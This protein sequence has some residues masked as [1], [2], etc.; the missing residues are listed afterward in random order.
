MNHFT[1]GLTTVAPRVW[2]RP[3]RTVRIRRRIGALLAT[4]FVLPTLGLAATAAPAGADDLALKQ[5]QAARIVAQLNA[6]GQ[7][8]S[9]LAE[10]LDQARVKAAALNQ[11]VAQAQASLAQTTAQMSAVRGRLTAQA[12]TA[13]ISGGGASVVQLLTAG[14]GDDLALRRHYA[15]T[16]AGTERG[17][18]EAMRSAQQ[19]L[20]ARQAQL[21]ADQK[22]AKAA[23]DQVDA[24]Q[25][26]AGSVDAQN[27]ALLASVQG[28]IATLVA[29]QQA[30]AAAATAARVQAELQAREAAQAASRAQAARSTTAATPMSAPR[31]VGAP[32][33]GA[34]AGAQPNYG[35]VPAGAAGAV[36]EAK[37][38]L[39]KPYQYGGA[40][41]DSFDCSGLTAWAWGHAGVSLPHSASEQ[42]SV[43]THIPVSALQPGDLV[44]YGSPPH[45]VGIYVG[46][47][48]MINALH[49]GTNVEYDSIY[50]EG[51]LVGGGRVN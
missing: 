3:F 8:I 31:P 10:Q 4:V 7:R 29:Q 9:A 11:Q 27:R 19:D 17:A 51:D 15:D 32:A 12:V 35:P 13:Y 39:G 21:R 47:G 1:S 45:H 41:P 24:A 36:E 5:A 28:D 23:L 49:S 46:N 16:V 40:G 48:Q 50:L 20:A 30:A 22:A 37:R 14:S 25:A 43:T 42:Y 26:A 38:Q 33:A 44:F 34:S 6:N 2:V 18:M